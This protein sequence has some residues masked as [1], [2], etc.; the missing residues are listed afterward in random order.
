LGAAEAGCF[1]GVVYYLGQW[2]PERTL[3]QAMSRFMMSIPL[4]GVIGGPLGGALLTLSGKF[5]LAGWQWLFLAEGV[6]SLVLGIALLF[7]FT[8]RPKDAHWLSSAEREWLTKT[9]DDER[10]VREGIAE[11]GA[12][13]ALTS[14]VVWWL[15]IAYFFAIA[16]E[17][18]PIFFG[19]SLVAEALHADALTVGL[20]MGG[21]GL[22]G[23]AGML[24]NGALSDR[25]GERIIHSAIPMLMMAAGFALTAFVREGLW[26]PIGLAVIS[27]SVNAFLPVFWCVPS[28]ILAGVG[29]AGG[30]ALIN[31]IGNLGGFFAPNIVGA[32]RQTSGSFAGPFIELGAMALAAGLMMLPM[33]RTRSFRAGLRAR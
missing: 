14:G 9:L 18:G 2:F 1:P 19:P 16:A 6:P 5:G 28:A 22:A 7:V 31:S 13:K 25:R 17:L 33:R 23:V 12:V 24:I 20:V 15:A 26:T 11:S 21:I 3:A 4:A 29:A 27:F 8:D 10:R 32:G 30:I